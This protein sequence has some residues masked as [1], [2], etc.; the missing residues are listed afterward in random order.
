MVAALKESASIK[1]VKRDEAIEV[2]QKEL[3]IV[4][5][6]K[7]QL[8]EEVADL[9]VGQRVV[10]ELKARVKTLEREIVG[11]KDA[12]ELAL[13]SHVEGQGCQ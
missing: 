7:K 2:L 8:A 3:D 4:E 5:A 13:A 11:S 10:E 6:E 9:R 12:E 1:V